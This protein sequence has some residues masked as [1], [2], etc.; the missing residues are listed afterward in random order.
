MIHQKINVNIICMNCIVCKSNN[1]VSFQI[2]DKMYFECRECFAKF[3]DKKHYLDKVQEKNHYLKHENNIH[4]K[5][6][7]KF[8][9]KI[10]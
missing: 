1:L 5:E 10:I 6:Y 3:I 9:S 7:L 4:D 2:K 8:L